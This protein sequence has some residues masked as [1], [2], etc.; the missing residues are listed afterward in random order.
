MSLCATKMK[1][2]FAAALLLRLA[3]TGWG[4]YQDYATPALKYTDID[5]SVFTD[6]AR[7]LSKGAFPPA[8]SITS[9]Q[10]TYNLT[11]Q[12][13][14]NRSTYRYTPI[15]AYL[16]LPNV[17]MTELFGK[18]LFVGADL[19]VGWI[20]WRLLILAETQTSGAALKG[21]SS[22]GRG[23]K[24]TANNATTYSALIKYLVAV[25]LL[26][27]FV[28]TISTRGNGKPFLCAE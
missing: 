7:Y 24:V 14:Y 10:T 4:V 9:P 5:Y 6:A 11:G 22:G 26:N 18:L 8:H 28:I 23:K 3:F 15:L 21:K 1:G 16:L 13:P 25:W 19:I 27:P 17:W 12:S 2:M 20:I